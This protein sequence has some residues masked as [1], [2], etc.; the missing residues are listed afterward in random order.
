MIVD[1]G[2]CLCKR[3]CNSTIVILEYINTNKVA[4]NWHSNLTSHCLLLLCMVTSCF[5]LK[6]KSNS[7][8]NNKTIFVL[9]LNQ[10][11]NQHESSVCDHD[12]WKD[13]GWQ[14]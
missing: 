3:T 5:F 12:L 4:S 8:S 6:T 9:H 11:T 14:E 1:E 10:S 2:F 7:N 13:S